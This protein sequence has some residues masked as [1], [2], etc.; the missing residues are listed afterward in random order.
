VLDL[1]L[2][3][4]LVT[5]VVVASIGLGMLAAPRLVA[6]DDRRAAGEDAGGRTLEPGRP[7]RPTHD[8]RE[9]TPVAEA[10]DTLDRLTFDVA[11]AELERT[12]AELEAGGLPLEET[13]ARYERGVALEQRCEQLL[14]DAELRVRRL[15]EGAR[16]ALTVAELALDAEGGEM[17]STPA[18]GEPE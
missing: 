9:V 7:A 18:P 8:R 4:G 1:V 17:P 2:F 3:L 16:G 12:V 14:A 5:L 15:V 6:W 13:I 11:L 10:P